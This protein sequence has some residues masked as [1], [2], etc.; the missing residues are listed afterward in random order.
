MIKSKLI[1]SGEIKKVE[2]KEN[3]IVVCASVYEVVS[4]E[5]GSSSGAAESH[6]VTLSY[7]NHNADELPA[8]PLTYADIA[9]IAGEMKV[10][11]FAGHEDVVLSEP[12]AIRYSKTKAFQRKDGM[13]VVNAAIRYDF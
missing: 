3:Y 13:I 11:G 8:N 4:E 7:N 6:Y 9:E 1:A 12:V 5:S 2:D 10:P